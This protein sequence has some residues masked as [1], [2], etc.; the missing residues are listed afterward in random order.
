LA[1]SQ[2]NIEGWS[3]HYILSLFLIAAG[4]LVLFLAIELWARDP[5][6]D[7]HLFRNPT[8]T[9]A[10]LVGMLLGC[11]MFAQNLLVPLFLQDYLEHTA[12]QAAI[13]MLPGV[14][15]TGAFSPLVGK[16]S[17]QFNPRHFLV[18]G[19]LLAAASSFWFAWMGPQPEES[20][21]IWALLVRA[22][23][24]FVFPPLM[25]LGLRTLARDQ[26][27]AAS[28]LSNITRQIA[29]MAGIAMAAVLLQRWHYTHHLTGSE[30][31]AFSG[32]ELDRTEQQ[33]TW[34]LHTAGEV[35]GFLEIKMQTMLSRYLTLESLMI[36][37][38]DCF[39]IVGWIFVA[40]ALAS[41]CIPG[42]ADNHS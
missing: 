21:L 12:L 37:F 17:D 36:A 3:S 9:V 31:L 34:L 28:G 4:S 13:L 41:L 29:G 5:L 32:L 10:T 22:G 40:A 25:N 7:L 20:T 15:L 18:L 23:L 27:G 42:G 1:L 14:I 16:L 24:G 6:V 30:H 8:Y 11:G 2:G 35:G 33:L 19:F 26:I 39:I 38:Q